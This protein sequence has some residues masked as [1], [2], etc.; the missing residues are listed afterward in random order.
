VSCYRTSFEVKEMPEGKLWLVLDEVWQG[1]SPHLG[2]LSRRKNVEIWLNGQQLPYLKDAHW[3]EKRLR[4]VEITPY[5]IAGDNLLEL[6]F[7]SL[8]DPVQSMTEPAYIIGNFR[9]QDGAI[10]KDATSID[11]YW[12]RVAM[13]T[14]PA[15]AC[16]KRPLHWARNLRNCKAL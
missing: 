13:L 1:L 12:N 5:V 16:I 7:I 15:P 2:F 8:L 4:E 6:D 9:V 11:G 10:V 14:I 3:Q